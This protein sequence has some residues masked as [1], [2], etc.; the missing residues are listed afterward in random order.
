VAFL[1]VVAF[2]T[3]VGVAFLAVVAFFTGAGVAFLAVVAFFTGVGVAFLAVVAFFT[4]VGVAFLAVVAFFTGVG[5]AFLAVVAFFT[6][7][8]VAFLAAVVAFGVV[9]AAAFTGVVLAVV[10]VLAGVLDVVARRGTVVLPVEPA[11]EAGAAPYK[12]RPA[13]IASESTD[14]QSL[15]FEGNKVE[16]LHER[17]TPAPAL[18]RPL[19][20]LPGWLQGWAILLALV[21]P[22]PSSSAVSVTRRPAEI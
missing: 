3:G 12:V 15:C 18:G 21:V 10:V 4:G 17:I 1:A 19:P 11:A 14:A 5:V 8:G 22:R 13:H 20:G 6:G 2:F 9:F 7:V 16:L